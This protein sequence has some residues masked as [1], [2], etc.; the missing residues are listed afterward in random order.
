MDGDAIVVGA[1]LAG[2][3][4]AAELVDAGKRVVI[5][6]QEH[7]VGGQAWWSF[8]VITPQQDGSVC[9][10]FVSRPST[11]P[12][13]LTSVTCSIGPTFATMPCDVET[14]TPLPWTA[15]TKIVHPPPSGDWAPLRLL[16]PGWV[17]IAI[18]KWL[19]RIEVIVSRFQ[20]HYMSV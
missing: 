19:D 5:V 7:T 16:V 2:L 15:L 6:E 14:K 18:V 1:G 12:P 20:G 10:P 9:V 3:V 11:R 17:G 8:G 4:A 13:W